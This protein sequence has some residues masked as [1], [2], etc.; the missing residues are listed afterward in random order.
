LPELFVTL[1]SSIK[2]ENEILIGTILGS[3]IANI[4]LM[5]GL[6][7][8]IRAIAI[9][10]Q[11]VWHEIPFMLLI[12]LLLWGFVS[13]Q[14]LSQTDGRWLLLV[15]V[16]FL[17]WM[18][19]RGKKSFAEKEDEGFKAH[20]IPLA[21]GYCLI[22]VTGLYFGG[23]WI[24]EGAIYIAQQFG[25]AESVIGLT[26]VAV[27]TTL[28]EIAASIAAVRKNRI[29]LAIG[30]AIGSNIFNILMV[31]GFNATIKDIPY[32]ASFD[33]DMYFVLGAALLLWLILLPQKGSAPISLW[34]RV[35]RW[36]L[37]PEYILKRWQ[38]G[39]FLVI[40]AVYVWS[41]I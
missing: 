25:I 17:G 21:L 4:L 22:G 20:P 15:F 37:G 33:Y 16:F 1:M 12:S 8:S 9:K 26:I 29:G 2:G 30:N 3:N 19:H 32:A 35:A 39:L 23:E 11:V 38:G 14:V 36:E 40:Y 31:L 24:V 27:G 28:P 6:C 5:L 18:V 7:T 13:D 34:K 10:P 41:L